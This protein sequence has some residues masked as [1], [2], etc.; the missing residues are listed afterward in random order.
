MK[1]DGREPLKSVNNSKLFHFW[2]VTMLMLKR[3][4]VVLLAPMMMM[5]MMSMITII[6]RVP[7][8]PFSHSFYD[9]DEQGVR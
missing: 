4:K 8:A 6:R 1:N 9:D 3:L 7:P 5:L 2:V